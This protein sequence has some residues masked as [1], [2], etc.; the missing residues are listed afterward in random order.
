[1][2]KKTT[3]TTLVKHGDDY[4]V[5]ID[6]SL[7]TE[8]GITAETHLEVFV[9]DGCLVIVP[10]GET[11]RRKRLREAMDR[12]NKRYGNCLRRLAD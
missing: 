7:L 8:L 2:T 10:A 3:T 9:A 5:V 1:M 4:A 12:I 6:E 11:D